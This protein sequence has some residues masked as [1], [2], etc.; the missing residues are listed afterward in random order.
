MRMESGIRTQPE[1]SMRLVNGQEQ[2]EF[3]VGIS[4][5]TKRVC[6]PNGKVDGRFQTEG[7]AESGKVGPFQNGRGVG[8]KADAQRNGGEVGE[9][10]A[11]GKRRRR[12][13]GEATPN[14]R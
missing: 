4:D 2:F 14:G 5:L 13:G 12:G 11:G 9:G 1:E 10:T 6:L 8:G 7:V 3:A